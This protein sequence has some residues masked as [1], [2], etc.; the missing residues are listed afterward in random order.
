MLLT[1]CCLAKQQLEQLTTEANKSRQAGTYTCTCVQ[2]CDHRPV[3]LH[4]WCVLPATA[5]ET[6][7]LKTN[8]QSA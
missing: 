6:C 2:A 4:D 7:T 5:Y 8:Q 3:L 1:T